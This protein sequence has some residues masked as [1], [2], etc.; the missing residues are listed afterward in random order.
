MPFDAALLLP[1]EHDVRSELAAV[2]ADDHAGI[3]S[4]RR[5]PVQL[6]GD[7]QARQRGVGDRGQALTGEVIDHRQNAE[8]PAL[9]QRVRDEVQG[10]ALVRPLRQGHRR[11]GAQSPLPAAPLPDHQPLLAIEPVELLVVQ[12]GPLPAEQDVQP[13]VAEAPAQARQLPQPRPDRPVIRP[14]RD[15]P[16][17][18]RMQPHQ[19]A[20]AALRVASLPNR[21]D[22]GIPAQPGR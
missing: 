15:I 3:A 19:P 21:P 22:H 18:L 2:V 12:H 10:P 20:P 4:A 13:P 7:P 11:A 1:A 5:Y 17:R 9:D 6:A 14:L 16:V 8:A